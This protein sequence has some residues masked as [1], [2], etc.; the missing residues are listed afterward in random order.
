V[1]DDGFAKTSNS[2]EGVIY[3]PLYRLSKKKFPSN[4]RRIL[5]FFIWFWQIFSGGLKGNFDF[6]FGVDPIGIIIGSILGQVKRTP[7]AYI[8]LEIY[9]E[10]DIT[11]CLI[12]MMK[13]P[14][15]Y[16]SQRA[17]FC[18]V[19]DEQRAELLVEANKVEREK[20]VLMPNAPLGP[21]FRG[22]STFLRDRLA[23]DK[24]KIVLL[25]A[26]TLADWTATPELIG[27]ANDWPEEY[28]LVLHSRKKRSE[29]EINLENLPESVLLSDQ[30][31]E[32]NQLD[33]LF[34]SADIG[35]VLYRILGNDWYGDNMNFVGLSSGK[36]AQCLLVGLP[37]IVSD[38]PGLKELIEKYSCGV[39][40]KDSGE[41]S[42]AASKILKNYNDFSEN[43]NRCFN[44]VFAL[45]NY[46]D[47]ILVRMGLS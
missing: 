25:H 38:L 2:L 21:A 27:A 9:L 16:F 1:D 34:S 42:Q 11:N 30:P 26:G 46:F 19:Q 13:K 37:V 20:I 29:I 6:I 39:A 14:E 22:K 4:F 12:R 36:L 28:L 43:A 7:I 10:K 3:H 31:V 17:A 47:E 15:N 8:N 18:V 33:A 32:Y 40:V 5:E 45:Q 23:I 44:E 41:V 24:D 35:L